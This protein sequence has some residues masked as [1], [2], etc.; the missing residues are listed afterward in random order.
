MLDQRA[1]EEGLVI[2]LLRRPG[3]KKDVTLA[4]VANLPPALT[5]ESVQNPRLR[6]LLA[7][8]LANADR[9]IATSVSL[10]AR[11]S[12]WD[13]F[14]LRGLVEATDADALSLYVESVLYYQAKR[15]ISSAAENA[16]EAARSES[17][18][19]AID[20]ITQEFARISL[21]DED[22]IGTIAER[23]RVGGESFRRRQEA[24]KRGDTRL[25]F[26][27]P[28]LNYLLPTILPGQVILLTAGSKIGKTSFASQMFDYNV[29]RGLRG[30]YFHF[31][32][33]TEVMHLRRVARGMVRF[34]DGSTWKPTRPIAT[35]NRLIGR[36]DGDFPPYLTEKEMESVRLVEESIARELGDRGIEVYSAGWTMQRVARV[37]RRLNTKARNAGH[38]I[39]FVVIDY[40][41]KAALRPDTLRSLG[42]NIYAA[43]GLD[44]ELIKQTAEELGIIAI[45]LQ[46]ESDEGL[47]YETRQSLQ[48]SQA[49]LSL[50]RE[51]YDNG[52]LSK[53][54]FVHVRN[55]NM[56]ETG[57]V[58]VRLLAQFMLWTSR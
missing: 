22:R 20:R 10:A 7:V 41:N 19:Q 28:R 58:S 26:P 17:P 31:E 24:M 4:R 8:V 36:K 49:W 25:A 53:Q 15:Q 55:A 51:R 12:D 34:M 37:W 44:V 30:I 11:S 42:N 6:K 33:T 2:S 54:G 13:E 38:K 1:A 27:I 52:E 9:D 29:R 35:W 16:L 47:P 45:L 23:A 43:R 18:E 21:S 50:Q 5:E 3:E 14:D 32:D 57:R 39:D 40:L 56:G 46:Q 48:K